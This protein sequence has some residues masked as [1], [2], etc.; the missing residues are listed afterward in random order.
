VRRGVWQFC[1]SLVALVLLPMAKKNM[2]GL[3]FIHKKMP[4]V[5]FLICGKASF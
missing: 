4:N 1:G 2:I 3:T 5:C